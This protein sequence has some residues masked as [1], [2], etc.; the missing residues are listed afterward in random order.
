M[1]RKSNRRVFRNLVE[2]YLR[3]GVRYLGGN[4]FMQALPLQYILIAFQYFQQCFTEHGMLS[5]TRIK[6][7]FQTAGSHDHSRPF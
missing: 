2:T 1:A 5:T 7:G 3:C 4:L 6:N